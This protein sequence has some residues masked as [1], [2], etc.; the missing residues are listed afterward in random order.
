MILYSFTNL[1]FYYLY[2]R[3]GSAIQI[4]FRAALTFGCTAFGALFSTLAVL[5]AQQRC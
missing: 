2:L 1:E 5:W 3:G 4:L